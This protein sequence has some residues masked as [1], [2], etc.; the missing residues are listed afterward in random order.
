VFRG[1]FQHAIDGKGRTSLPSRFREVLAATG[2]SRV[3]IS[4]V[5]DQPCLVAY[6]LQEWIAF[7]QRLEAAPQLDPVVAMYQRVYLS[8]AVDCEV[9]KLGRLLI[10]APLRE[11]AGLQRDAL[12]IGRVKCAELWDKQRFEQLRQEVLSDPERTQAI[13]KRIAE[14]VS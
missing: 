4:T 2:E 5:I 9:D 8:D 7:E 10:P 14:L 13:A 1:R 12:W 11:Y 3:V 6:P